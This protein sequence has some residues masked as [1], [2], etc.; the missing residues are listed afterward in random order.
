M[1]QNQDHYKNQRLDNAAQNDQQDSWYY[2]SYPSYNSSHQ[3]Q[4]LQN[5]QPHEKRA[6]HSYQQTSS[7][8]DNYA[9]YHN[10]YNSNYEQQQQQQPITQSGEQ[11]TWY[12]DSGP[13]SSAYQQSEQQAQQHVQS[14]SSYYYHN[15]YTNDNYNALHNQGY[16][17]S[18]NQQESTNNPAGSTIITS[19]TLPA[20]NPIFTKSVPMTSSNNENK[21]YEQT[22]EQLVETTINAISNN[23]KAGSNEPP[24]SSKDTG[25]M[26]LLHDSENNV[27]VIT[28][29]ESD[30]ENS[31]SNSEDEIV[32]SEDKKDEENT[33]YEYEDEE[34]ENDSDSVASYKTASDEP[35][36][37]DED[38]EDEDNENNAILISD[39]N[40]TGEKIEWKMG[41]HFINLINEYG[42]EPGVKHNKGDLEHHSIKL[43][44]LT[45][46]FFDKPGNNKGKKKW[47]VGI[48]NV[49]TF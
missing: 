9:A 4:D 3:S 24:V 12:V 35:I 16:A 32:E 7:Y 41:K 26:K 29:D 43:P 5:E 21:Q 34:L 1:S 48:Q 22:P 17:P 33:G 31:D 38:E 10:Y 14:Y 15:D 6:R 8:Y 20:A 23:E 18:H 42:E 19:S 44:L 25:I 11:A 2:D 40:S 28:D 27:A 36:G 49:A 45:S 39:I 30:G 13:Y 46:V 47:A 37:F